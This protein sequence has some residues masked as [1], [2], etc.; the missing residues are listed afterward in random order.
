MA[1][2]PYVDPEVASPATREALEAVPPLNIFRMLAH[3]DTAF[4]PW[5]RWGAALLGKLEL[6]PVLRELAILRVARL[7]PHADYEWVQHVPI[8]EA[9]GGRSEQVAAL[10]RDEAGAECFSAEERATIAFTTEVVRDARAGDP[11]FEA[12][13]AF[14]SPREIVELLMVIGNYML[15]AR[16]MATTEIEMDPP[17]GAEGLR[18]VSGQG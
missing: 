17:A 12:V 9:V 3:A 1:R 5:L 4:R 15:V 6:D 13:A 10:E 7:T 8:F 18:V 2:L 11:T 16:V 14:L